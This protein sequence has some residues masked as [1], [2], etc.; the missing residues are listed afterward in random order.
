VPRRRGT[1]SAWGSTQSLWVG[2]GRRY[3]T[4][5]K[6]S[7]RAGRSERAV[8]FSALIS[9]STASIR[10]SAARSSRKRAKALSGPSPRQTPTAARRSADSA[11]RADAPESTC[12]SERS[13]PLT[14]VARRGRA[15]RPFC[16][17][18]R[19]NRICT[20]AVL[21][22]LPLWRYSRSL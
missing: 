18:Q 14:G 17:R 2:R 4:R 10:S 5:R 12:A 1:R 11:A 16:T 7:A 9:A 6:D 19:V 15:T 21:V 8:A 13:G 20:V 22:H 3:A